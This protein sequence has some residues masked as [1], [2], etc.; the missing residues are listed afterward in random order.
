MSYKQ[1]HF[2]LREISIFSK[3]TVTKGPCHN[4]PLNAEHKL[5]DFVGLEQQ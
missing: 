4:Q 2:R 5:V 1:R 3:L